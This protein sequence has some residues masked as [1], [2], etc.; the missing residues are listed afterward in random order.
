MKGQLCRSNFE[1]NSRKCLRFSDFLLIK[2]M[3]MFYLPENLLRVFLASKISQNCKFLK[4]PGKL[5]I[6]G[7]INICMYEYD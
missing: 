7:T 2:R 3:G 6:F 4:K 5:Q 1:C